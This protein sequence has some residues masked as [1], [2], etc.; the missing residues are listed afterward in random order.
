MATSKISSDSNDKKDTV[1]KS[2]PNAVRASKNDAVANDS[3]SKVPEGS[4][5]PAPPNAPYAGVKE[6]AANLPDQPGQVPFNHN[7]ADR[8][9]RAQQEDGPDGANYSA[10]DGQRASD[11]IPL[12]GE[13]GNEEPKPDAA[14]ASADELDDDEDSEQDDEPTKTR[15][16]QSRAAKAA[17]KK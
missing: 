13:P 12:K 10:P 14:T 1:A 6:Q 3:T 16:A 4:R 15:K 7:P 8:P 5:I 17:R 11:Y 9:T 2:D